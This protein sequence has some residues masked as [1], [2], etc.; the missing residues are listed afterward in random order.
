VHGWVTRLQR[1]FRRHGRHAWVAR[2]GGAF[3]FSPSPDRFPLD[4]LKT[5][6]AAASNAKP[7][8]E[9]L[10]VAEA[11]GAAAHRGVDLAFTIVMAHGSDPVKTKAGAGSC[12]RWSTHEDT[13][14]GKI[15]VQRNNLLQI[16]YDRVKGR[17]CHQIVL[18]TSCYGTLTANAGSWLNNSGKLRCGAPYNG[19]KDYC[20]HAAFDDVYWAGP[21]QMVC[22]YKNDDVDLMVDTV[23]RTFRSAASGGEHAMSDFA[24]KFALKWSLASTT[25]GPPLGHKIKSWF[26]FGPQQ[27]RHGMPYD[28]VGFSQCEEQ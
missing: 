22:T 20:S 8:Q 15:S 1:H 9:I 28:S 18:D 7:E 25:T 5:R 26:G 16:V 17:A 3:G 4:E 21:G 2:K 27:Q 12:G 14:Q 11:F 13:S 19:P 24:R 6:L 23:T 10:A